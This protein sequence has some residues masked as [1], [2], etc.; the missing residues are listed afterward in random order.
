MRAWQV[1]RLG[2]PA[3]VM[4]LADVPEPVVQPGH[5]VVEVAATALNFP[6][7]L[8]ARG[9]YQVQPPLPFVPGVEVCGRVVEVGA[10]VEGV[11]VGDRVVGMPSL[12]H[13]GLAARAPIPAPA[14]FP[15]PDAL[16]DA[17]AAALTIG[18]QTAYVGLVRRAG[19]QPGEILL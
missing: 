11:R 4:T 3:D 15:A 7:V 2:E 5:V 14:L 10:G 6:D 9:E 16:D 18:Y 12:P 17:E 19:L 1:G 13:G 8:M